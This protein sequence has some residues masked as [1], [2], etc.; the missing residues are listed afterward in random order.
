MSEIAQREQSEPSTLEYWLLKIINHLSI[1]ALLLSPAQASQWFWCPLQGAD[2]TWRK[3]QWEKQRVHRQHGGLNSSTWWTW[4]F[5]RGGFSGKA[6]KLRLNNQE[7][8]RAWEK[9]REDATSEHHLKPESKEITQLYSQHSSQNSQTL[10]KQNWLWVEPFLQLFVG[11]FVWFFSFCRSLFSYRDLL[12]ERFIYAIQRNLA[13]RP[14]HF[15][16]FPLSWCYKAGNVTG[17]PWDHL[18]KDWAAAQGRHLCPGEHPAL[19]EAPVSNRNDFFSCLFYISQIVKT[20]CP[21]SVMVSCYHHTLLKRLGGDSLCKS[22]YFCIFNSSSNWQL[23][24]AVF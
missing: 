13:K 24:L 11:L 16:C 19:A 15:F 1:Q 8:L 20:V 21:R 4:G 3:L 2:S 12:M 22:S 9:K 17:A 10:R 5:L 23:M 6:T 14:K 7:F 18:G